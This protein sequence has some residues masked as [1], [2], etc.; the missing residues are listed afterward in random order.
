M[1]VPTDSTVQELQT[2]FAYELQ[3]IP[4]NSEDPIKLQKKANAALDEN[5]YRPH[6][7]C[8]ASN[9]WMQVASSP[10]RV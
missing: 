9:L 5:T 3:A 1:N 8:A 6:F 7:T 2:T 10:Y 4:T